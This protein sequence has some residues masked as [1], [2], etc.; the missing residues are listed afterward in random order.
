MKV[1]LLDAD[2]SVVRTLEPELNGTELHSA[3]SLSDG[4]RLLAS[5]G[6]DLILLDAD[7]SGA[8]ME[9]L[10]RLHRD[11]DGTPVVLLSAQ[12]SMDL[13]MEAIR[14]GAHDVLPKPVP[15][16]R[17]REILLGIEEVRRLRPLPAAPADESAIVGSSAG[18]MAVFK[19][20]ARAATS[21]ATVLVLGESGTGKE[22]VARV[23]HA[24]SRRARGRFVAI[25]CAAIPENL[26][27]SEL[28]G[29]EKGAFT[30][31][32]GRRIGRFERASSGTLFLDEIGDMSLALQ[33]K[34]LRAIQEREIER[35][36]GGA[37]V[38]IDVRIVAATNHDLAAA[39]R[40]GRFRED[41]YYRLAV[42]TLTLPPL[43]ERGTDLDLLASHF[44]AHYAREHARGVRAVAE[45]V[46]ATLRAHPWPGNVRQLRN[47]M[48]RAVVM[49]DGEVLLPQHLP[50]EILAPPLPRTA[51]EPE[52]MPLLT[53]QEMEKR[54]IRRALD[55]THDNLTVAAEKLGIH[56][57][58]LRRKIA[59]YGIEH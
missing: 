37:P 24:R 47:A 4:L 32:I 15:R 41:L 3:Q 20:A 7:F 5:A 26:L 23:L 51:A 54:M 12:P 42:V 14:Y 39:V 17:V 1:L 57:N 59:E 38:A 2:R 33:S 16:G 56:R 50:A 18:M 19:S 25:N 13:A 44:V 40:E 30:G 43:R 35:V 28:F 52:R 11:G 46:Y 55:E 29:H 36:G 34:I 21:D 53:L 49:A 9:L 6:W 27:E 45:E 58:T 22:M 8:G 48:E 31:A 10:G